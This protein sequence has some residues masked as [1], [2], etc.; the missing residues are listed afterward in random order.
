[1]QGDQDP[2]KESPVPQDSL[3]SRGRAFLGANVPL[4]C[5]PPFQGAFVNILPHGWV[6]AGSSPSEQV[7]I[8]GVLFSLQ[9]VQ[10]E[11]GRAGV[12]VQLLGPG[13]LSCVA[14]TQGHTLDHRHFSWKSENGTP[15]RPPKWTQPLGLRTEP[16]HFL[17]QVHSCPRPLLPLP[18]RSLHRED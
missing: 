8:T 1:M 6:L 12:C 17:G 16:S 5:H 15:S 11:A 14:W 2:Q 18:S 7:E 10:T 3:A 13:G 4:P 9:S